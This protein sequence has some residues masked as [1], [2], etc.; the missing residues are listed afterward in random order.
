MNNNQEC[1]DFLLKQYLLPKEERTCETFYVKK[2]P[3]FYFSNS[4]SILVLH[5]E[6]PNGSLAFW[7]YTDGGTG[8]AR[9]VDDTKKGFWI[10]PQSI[11]QP[12]VRSDHFFMQ[13][14]SAKTMGIKINKT[15][16]FQALKTMCKRNAPPSFLVG[17]EDLKY[18]II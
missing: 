11:F 4:A 15:I 14:E 18:E 2:V 12:I 9:V 6:H 16:L 17:V 13:E 3:E 5:T 8:Y 7:L 10:W 1:F